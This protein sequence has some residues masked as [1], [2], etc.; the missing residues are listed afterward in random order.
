MRGRRR[1]CSATCRRC[2]IPNDPLYPT[3]WHLNNTGAQLPDALAGADAKLSAAWDVSTG[4][5]VTIAI[6]DDGMQRDHPD[7]A[8]NI[9]INPGEVAGDNIDNDGNGYIDDV[10]GWSF[11]TNSPN[12]SV[13]SNDEHATSV[14]G[15]AAAAGTTRWA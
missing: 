11:V 14:A 2:S 12:P 6:V 3:Q 1:T 4:A 13:T 5:G 9:F 7:L 10:S 15:I 8:A